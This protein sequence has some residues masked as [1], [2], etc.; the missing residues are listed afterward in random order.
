VIGSREEAMDSGRRQERHRTLKAGKI[1]FNRKASVVDCT[2]R[3]VS[4]GGACLL[5]DSVVGIP[6]T[7]DLAIDQTVRSCTVKWKSANRIGVSFQ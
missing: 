4:E 7:F 6:E 1:I 5:V 3:N 2:I